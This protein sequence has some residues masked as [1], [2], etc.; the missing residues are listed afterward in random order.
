MGVGG[1]GTLVGGVHV[2]YDAVF[3]GGVVVFFGGGHC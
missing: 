3:D 2:G 1:E